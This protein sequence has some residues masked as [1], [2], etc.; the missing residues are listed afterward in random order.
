[1]QVRTGHAPCGAD[2]ADDLAGLD[3]IARPHVD[4]RQM[5]EQRKQTQ[6]VIDHDGVP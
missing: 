2:L 5:R 4:R 6:A 1:V 3:G